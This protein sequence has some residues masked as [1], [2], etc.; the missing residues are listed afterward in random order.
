[1]RLGRL[2][3]LLT[4]ILIIS[5]CSDIDDRDFADEDIIHL[6]MLQQFQVLEDQQDYWHLMHQY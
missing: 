6:R 3:P 4:A 5:S 1:M 2:I